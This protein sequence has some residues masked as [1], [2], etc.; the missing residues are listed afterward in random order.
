MF[1]KPHEHPR[2]D[3]AIGP[4]KGAYTNAVPIH[5]RLRGCTVHHVTGMGTSVYICSYGVN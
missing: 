5:V 3:E 1:E 4:T 2:H